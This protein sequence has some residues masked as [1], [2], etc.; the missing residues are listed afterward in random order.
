ML[1]RYVSA[2][3]EPDTP[4][5]GLVAPPAYVV[6]EMSGKRLGGGPVRVAFVG[7][8][9]EDSVLP[10]HTGFRVT[11]PTAALEKVLPKARAESDL[12]VVLAYMSPDA[13]AALS[14]KL[15]GQVDAYIVS[16][17][18]AQEAEPSIDGPE[19]VT[20]A[21]YQTKNLG[22]LRL[23]LEGKKLTRV[24]NRYV[25]LDD[26]LPKDPVAEK[27]AAEA[28]EAIKQAQIDRFNGGPATST[29]PQGP[30]VPIGPAPS[31]GGGGQ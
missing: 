12:V 7:L 23:F 26:Q 28:K 21:R 17:I 1:A 16:N 24:A 15:K 22:E 5:S 4:G 2:N 13:V 11:D 29:V 25:S 9:E 27:M 6:R 30:E 18:K 10:L 31:S 20:Y 19:R 3:L 14:Q 8:T